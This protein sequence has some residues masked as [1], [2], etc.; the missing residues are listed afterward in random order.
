MRGF[1]IEL[2]EIEAA[3]RRRAGGARGRGRGARGRRRAT[4]ASWPTWSPRRA[5]APGRASCATHLGAQRCPSTWC[6]PRSSSSTA[7]PL[8]PQRQGGPPRPARA[9]GRRRAT[10]A[11]VG[12]A[13]PAEE[14]LAEIWADVLGVA[15]VGRPRQLLRRS[16][17]T[18][19]CAIQVARAGA[20]ALGLDAD[21]AAVFERRRCAS[22][23]ADRRRRRDGRADGAR[24]ASR[25][26]TAAL[27]R[28]LEDAYPLSPPAGGMLFHSELTPERRPTTTSSA[29]PATARFDAA[30][31]PTR[32]ASA[33]DRPHDPAHL[34]RHGGLR[35][36][37]RSSCTAACAT[38]PGGRRIS[39]APATAARRTRPSPLARAR[40][41]APVRLAARRR[42]CASAST[43]GPTRPSSSR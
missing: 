38:R 22:W 18:R 7:L 5:A 41:G 23:R 8:T 13:D 30:A 39:P 37:A 16:A 34:V 15:R 21:A 33:L 25:R 43:G 2:G 14:T 20:R 9:R 11:Y 26:R 12:P 36:A 19:S 35:R 31:L 6:R 3:A 4:S 40:E 28:G 42:C 27:P 32:P 29:P 24:P 17:A 10:G 1:R